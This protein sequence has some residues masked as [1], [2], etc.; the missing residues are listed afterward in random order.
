MKAPSAHPDTA[1]RL[2]GDLKAIQSKLKVYIGG[3]CLHYSM[4]AEDDS[5]HSPDAADLKQVFM[6][7]VRSPGGGRQNKVSFSCIPAETAPPRGTIGL[8]G[9]EAGKGKCT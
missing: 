7:R 2:M 1:A 8:P 3:A 9:E 6:M 5:E 4:V